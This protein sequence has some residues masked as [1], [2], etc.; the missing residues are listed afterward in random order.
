[1]NIENNLIIWYCKGKLT[2]MISHVTLLFERDCGYFLYL[3]LQIT[4][5]PLC[6][7]FLLV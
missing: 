2:Q 7:Y 5:C 4:N 1:M 3:W 6:F